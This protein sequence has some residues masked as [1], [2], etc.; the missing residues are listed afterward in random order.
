MVY[1]RVNGK[2]GLARLRGSALVLL[3]GKVSDRR[4]R[5]VRTRQSRAKFIEIAH[6]LC[7]KHSR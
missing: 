4:Y 1:W 7:G 6:K 2:Y 5:K 3:G